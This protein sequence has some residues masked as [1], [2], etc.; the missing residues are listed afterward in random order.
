MQTNRMFKHTALA[1]IAASAVLFTG[2]VQAEKSSGAPPSCSNAGT[3]TVLCAKVGANSH[4]CVQDK[5]CRVQPERKALERKAP[6][7]R[8][9][10]WLLTELFFPRDR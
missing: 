10:I 4:R 6:D 7:E 8:S 3:T 1:A 5:S 2:V 9:A